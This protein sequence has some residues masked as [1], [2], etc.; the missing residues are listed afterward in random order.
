MRKT[1]SPPGDELGLRARPCH[2]Y[3]MKAVLFPAF[4]ALALFAGCAGKP[5]GLPASN[6]ILNFDQVST[7][8][9]RGAEPDA[10]GMAG[11]DRVGIRSVIDL[12]KVSEVRPGERTEAMGFGMTYTNIPM[13]G[14]GRP[15]ASEIEPVLE[16][17]RTLPPPVFV[18]CRHGCDRTGTVIA[19]YRIRH[20]GWSLERAME[21]ARV[22][23]MS[24]FEAGMESYIED[25]ARAEAAKAR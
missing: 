18:H 19:C 10:T 15:A 23:G 5:R 24:P 12:R 8:L 3:G 11:L 4:L 14:F 9:Y 6:G 20:D 21:E 22:H 7:N 2:H 16:L 13:A 1:A 17:I 25:F